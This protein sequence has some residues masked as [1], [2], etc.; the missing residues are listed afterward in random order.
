[1][2]GYLEA[3]EAFPWIEKLCRT[4]IKNLEG[5]LGEDFITEELPY[6][7]ANTID[8]WTRLQPIL[9]NPETDKFIR[10]AA[11]DALMFSVAKQKTDRA[12]IIAYFKGLF[13]RILARELDEDRFCTYLISSCT[14][15]WPEELLEEIREC[16]GLELVDIGYIDIDFVPKALSESKESLMKKLERRI[17]QRSLPGSSSL[18][19]LSDPDFSKKLDR[20]SILSDQA[21][22]MTD[23]FFHS[24]S[25][26]MERNAVCSCGSGRKYKKC[27]LQKQHQQEISIETS[28]IS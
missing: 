7:L 5:S 21:V 2:A 4:P 23:Q 9:E 8:Q 11:L 14:D 26:K 19:F 15:L 13:V 28:T 20:M 1:M 12:E 27:C 18:S 6:V 3:S 22:L 25:H 10:I 17:E 24:S 16:F